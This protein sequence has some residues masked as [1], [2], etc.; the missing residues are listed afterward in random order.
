MRF[1]EI[2]KKTKILHIIECHGP[3][4]FLQSVLNVLNSLR[5]N[6]KMLDFPKFV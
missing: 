3:L 4:L 6:D 2:D 1:S 5:K